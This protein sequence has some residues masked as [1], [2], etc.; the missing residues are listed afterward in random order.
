MSIALPKLEIPSKYDVIPIHASDVAAFKRCRR[1]WDWSSPTRTN[2]RRRVDINGVNMPL[3]FGSGVHYAL[4]MYYNPVLSRDPVEAFQT[5]YEYQWNGGIVTEDW[6]ERLYDLNPEPLPDGLWRVKGLSEIHPDPIKEEFEAHYELGVGMMT[7]YKEYATKNDNFVVVSAESKF[8]VPLG[9]EAIDGREESPNYG[10]SIEVHARGTRDGIIYNPDTDRYGFMD[11]KT[12]ADIG[13][14]YFT[15]LEM[16]EQIGTYFWASQH[17]AELHDLPYKRI[18]RAVY[19]VLRK[20][21]PKSPTILKDGFSPSIDRKNEST[22]AELFAAH[23]DKM[24]IR[25]MYDNSE[26]WQSYYNWLV[27]IG[28][29]NFI[30][31]KE[32]MRNKAQIDATA[33]HYRMVAKEMLSPHLQIY[34]TPS[35]NWLCNKCQFRAPCLA[36]DDGSDYVSMLSDGYEL[37]VGR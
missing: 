22:T 23:I 19:N 25:Q 36:A 11:H 12:A 24:G 31:R 20:G 8:S 27:Q 28:D 9:F 16:D 32:V 14:D 37:N 34:P 6:L 33:H 18:D 15:K 2:L 35:G 13:D 29:T 1:Y 4:E 7:F 17:E 10:K 30:Q 21:Y 3:W 5:W 26:K